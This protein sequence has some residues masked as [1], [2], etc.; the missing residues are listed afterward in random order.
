[1][2][3]VVLLMFLI[4]SVS[5]YAGNNKNTKITKDTKARSGIM[6]GQWVSEE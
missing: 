6:K 2:K 3:K 4:A 5:V 1:M